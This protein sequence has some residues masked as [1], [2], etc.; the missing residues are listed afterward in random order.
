VNRELL[1][2]LSRFDNTCSRRSI[3]W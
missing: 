1:I 2:D 3:E